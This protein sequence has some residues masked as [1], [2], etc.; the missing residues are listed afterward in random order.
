MLINMLFYAFMQVIYMYHY[1]QFVNLL[2]YTTVTFFTRTPTVCDISNT[3]FTY[4]SM[5]QLY[6]V[7][8]NDYAHIH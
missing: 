1:K 8:Q 3:L 6:T 7:Y 4:I 2:K 5:I